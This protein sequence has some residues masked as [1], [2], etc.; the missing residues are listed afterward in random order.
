MSDGPNWK[1][2]LHRG[3]EHTGPASC[4]FFMLGSEEDSAATVLQPPFQAANPSLSEH[5]NCLHNWFLQL[6]ERV[7]YTQL[8]KVP[9]QPPST[10]C[11]LVVVRVNTIGFFS[12][13]NSRAKFLLLWFSPSL[14]FGYF[15]LI[16][17]LWTDL[18]EDNVDNIINEEKV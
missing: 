5:G 11:F 1:A 16:K 8:Y 9:L 4:V 18:T 13:S 12:P 14:I 7:L 3:G 17:E 10:L 15:C 6:G 2:A